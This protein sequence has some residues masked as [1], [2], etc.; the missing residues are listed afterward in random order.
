MNEGVG[1]AFSREVIVAKPRTPPIANGSGD[2][3]ARALTEGTTAASTEAVTTA[4][5]P[6]LPLQA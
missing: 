3:V 2:R 4:P 5:T 6:A 1:T